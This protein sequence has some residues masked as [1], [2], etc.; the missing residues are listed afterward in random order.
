MIPHVFHRDGERIKEL[1]G[2]WQRACRA[3]GCPGRLVHD[4]RRTA[5]RNLER[6]GASR[7][8]AMADLGEGVSKLAR[9]HGAQDAPAAPTV[10]PMPV[11]RSTRAK[12]AR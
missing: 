6:A 9:L 2:A 1:R 7:S 11:R 8:V 4:F 3:A 10:V 12:S 5:V